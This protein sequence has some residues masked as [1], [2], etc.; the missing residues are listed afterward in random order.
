MDPN[1]ARQVLRISPDTP[2]TPEL[3]ETAYAEEALARHPSRYPDDAGRA[4]AEEWA[5]TLATARE[6]LLG[7][8]PGAAASAPAVA[9]AQERPR[10]RL[11]TWAITGIVAGGVA[12]VVLLAF[13]VVGGVRLVTEAAD[14]VNEAIE[15]E[16]ADAEAGGDPT[17]P[18]AVERFQSGETLYAFPA[19]LEIYA[20][21]RFNP[22]CPPGYAFGCW[23]MA[24]FTEADCGALQV[25]LGFSNDVDAL[26]PDLRE[27][28]DV[29]DVV[30]NEA[31]PLVFGND[32]YDYGWVQQVTCLD[33]NG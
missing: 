22:E 32:D 6:V 23:Q 11:S 16:E 3:I 2:L 19:A 20:D 26:L 27:T 12:V 25:E 8:L 30:G 31:T 9:P 4:Q 33:A 28:I 1:T 15:A 24:L 5:S 10:R 7:R 21:G 13:A 14:S 17:A 29:E 18:P